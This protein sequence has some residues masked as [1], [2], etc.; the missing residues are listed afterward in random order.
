M[1]LS[2]FDSFQT[3]FVTYLL[4]FPRSFETNYSYFGHSNEILW[5]GDLNGTACPRNPAK[6]LKDYSF[7]I[8]CQLERQ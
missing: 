3:R 8:N 7:G 2:P 5:M 6:C 4:N 1:S